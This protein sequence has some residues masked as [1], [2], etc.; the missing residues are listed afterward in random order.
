MVSTDAG[1]LI[2]MKIRLILLF[3]TLFTLDYSWANTSSN[4]PTQKKQLKKSSPTRITQ[5]LNAGIVVWG[6]Y[7]QLL[8]FDGREEE[9]DVKYSGLNLSYKMGYIFKTWILG[10]NLEAWFLQGRAISKGV[11]IEYEDKAPFGVPAIASAYAEY[12]PQKNVSLTLEA[13]ALYHQLQLSQPT[14]IVTSYEFKYS[15]AI[16]PLASLSL[17]WKFL[18]NLT[19]SERIIMFP[20]STLLSPAWNVS[21]LYRF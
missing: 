18:K 3:F 9:I 16:K 1:S 11:N 4:E 20:N 19:F 12:F 2:T 21:V 13:G 15:T 14:S 10:A 17:N 5:S 8:T 6:E 7:I